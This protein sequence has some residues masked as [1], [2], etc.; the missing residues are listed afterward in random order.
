MGGKT[1]TGQNLHGDDHAASI[2]FAPV[3]APTIAIAVLVENGGHGGSTAAPIAHQGLVARLLPQALDASPPARPG[4]LA[5][6]WPCCPRHPA[7]LGD[8]DRRGPRVSPT[9][10]TSGQ[11]DWISLILAVLGLVTIGLLLVYS[12]TSHAGS[13]HLGLPAA[14]HPVRHRCGLRLRGRGVPLPELDTLA[15]VGY[16]LSIVPLV[17]V[18]FVGVEVYGAKRRC[19]WAASSSSPRAGLASTIFVLACAISTRS[20]STWS[21]AK[22]W[23]PS[24]SWSCPWRWS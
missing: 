16:V 18:F 5:P 7:R 6:P 9:G 17:A 23:S 22:N 14:A 2:C 19:A 10:V 20:A 8:G 11:I 4:P 15:W 24:S 12:A 21:R 1:G 3:E 13:A